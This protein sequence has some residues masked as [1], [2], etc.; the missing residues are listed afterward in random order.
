MMT[1]YE[2]VNI[3]LPDGHMMAHVLPFLEGMGVAFRGYEKTHDNRRPVL[4][5]RSDQAKRIIQSPER[6]TAKIIRPQDMPIHVANG[7]FDMAVTGTDWVDEH[8][9]C[10]P[11]SPLKMSQANP[12]GHLLRLGFGQVRIVAAVRDDQEDNLDAFVRSFEGDYIRIAS[13]YVYL[14][15]RFAQEN[16]IYPYRV[17]MTYGATESL[18][19]EDCDM[20]IENTETGNTL[21]QNKLKILDAL[22]VLGA[23]QSEGCLIANP[24][25]MQD[26]SKKE[27]IRGVFDLFKIYLQS[28]PAA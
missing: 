2:T 23:A 27:M 16:Q 19:P 11:A 25:S 13:E 17:I 3:A 26:S 28:K 8:L 14:A 20:I 1:T 15:D 22:T 10:F 12:N 5:L 21:K 18:I 6:I 24:A 9:K 7:N 4:E